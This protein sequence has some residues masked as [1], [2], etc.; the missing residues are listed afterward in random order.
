MKSKKILVLIFIAL[1]VALFAN[2]MIIKS[3][4][5]SLSKIENEKEIVT[6]I[7]NIDDEEKE[8]IE[9]IVVENNT[10]EQEIEEKTHLEAD[11]VKVNNTSIQEE[12]KKN[13]TIRQEN[14]AKNTNKN[15]ESKTIENDVIKKEQMSNTVLENNANDNRENNDEDTNGTRVQEEKKSKDKVTK[16]PT[17]SDLDY[18][19]AEG[20]TH[21]IAGD[22][23]NEHGYYSSWN[24][25][26]IAFENYTKGWP[27]VQYKISQCLCG[28]YY[29]WAIK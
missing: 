21:H 23:A 12:P 10:E 17:P 29:F 27:S 28:K 6:E 24:E 3:K 18:W 25:A 5:L 9:V 7:N 11:I 19:C 1:I 14:I 15:E 4:K 16:K 20:G 13:P 22:G 2:M 8:D 26:Q